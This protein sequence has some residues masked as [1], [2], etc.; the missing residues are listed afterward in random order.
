M[1][2]SRDGYHV[3]GPDKGDLPQTSRI[4]GLVS[5]EAESQDFTSS[6]RNL[7]NSIQ[8]TADSGFNPPQ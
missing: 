6:S 3:S 5:I 4:A 7:H 2:L 1:A 8:H